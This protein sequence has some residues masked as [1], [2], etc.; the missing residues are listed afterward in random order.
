MEI[1]T[2]SEL[3]NNFCYCSNWPDQYQFGFSLDYIIK[4]I[5]NLNRIF[6]ND[7]INIRLKE[8]SM[9]LSTNIILSPSTQTSSSGST[10]YYISHHF[11]NEFIQVLIKAHPEF[12]HVNDTKHRTTTMYP[13]RITGVEIE[14]DRNC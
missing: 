1:T 11:I 14:Y 9:V 10:N 12:T 8:S 3:S 7:L 4:N 6:K 2:L 5:H 13:F